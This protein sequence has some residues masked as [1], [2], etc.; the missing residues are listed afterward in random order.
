MYLTFNIGGQVL[1]F[2]L[3]FQGFTAFK[4]FMGIVLG[5]TFMSIGSMKLSSV[6][7]SGVR[8]GTQT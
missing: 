8:N 2:A 3:N 1:S 4:I 7:I 5:K 6:R